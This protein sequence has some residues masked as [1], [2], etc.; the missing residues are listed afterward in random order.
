MMI[1]FTIIACTTTMATETSR[2][3]AAWIPYGEL[4]V[5]VAGIII[6]Q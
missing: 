3:T 5:V 4:L 6:R 2:V 1:R